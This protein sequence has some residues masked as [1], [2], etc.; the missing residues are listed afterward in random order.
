MTLLHACV[1]LRG[2]LLAPWSPPVIHHELAL[3][4]IAVICSTDAVESVTTRTHKRG[5]GYCSLES[6]CR[7]TALNF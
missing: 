1:K 5:H 4:V 2:L 7:C 6:S 3:A